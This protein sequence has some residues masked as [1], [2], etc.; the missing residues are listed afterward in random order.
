M[1]AVAC[2]K[3]RSAGLG[4]SSDHS[5]VSYWLYDFRLVIWP[6]CDQFLIHIVETGHLPRSWGS[7]LRKRCT[8]IWAW[9]KHGTC[10]SKE[11]DRSRPGKGV[12]RRHS[13]VWSRRQTDPTQHL[14]ASV[15]LQA[16]H[17]KR[18]LWKPNT[19][20]QGWDCR[21]PRTQCGSHTKRGDPLV[22]KN[23]NRWTS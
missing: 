2:V 14:I 19:R 13:R 23:D 5:S 4:A 18:G 17:R 1:G 9:R 8:L 22:Q 11:T 21:P 15:T 3:V 6:L 12:G 16:D 7:V 20:L 10:L